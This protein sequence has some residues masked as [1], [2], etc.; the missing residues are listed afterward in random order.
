VYFDSTAST[1]F[2]YVCKV[3]KTFM[4]TIEKKL[5]VHFTAK[6]ANYDGKQKIWFFYF[7]LKII[8]YKSFLCLSSNFYK[9]IL[10]IF[11]PWWFNRKTSTYLPTT[12]VGTLHTYVLY[13]CLPTLHTHIQTYTHSRQKL[14]WKRKKHNLTN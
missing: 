14:I 10:Y 4:L 8:L 5:Q 9:M 1:I 3:C 6:N 7:L 13:T 12:Y 11:L 2:K